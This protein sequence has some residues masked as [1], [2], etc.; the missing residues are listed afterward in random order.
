MYSPRVP[1]QDLRPLDLLVFSQL[2]KWSVESRKAK[3]TVNDWVGNFLAIPL[4]NVGNKVYPKEA[5]IDHFVQGKTPQ[6]V[7]FGFLQ[8]SFLR[9]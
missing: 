8:T 9:L 4:S 1:D 2:P 5:I 3:N 7:G 6:Q